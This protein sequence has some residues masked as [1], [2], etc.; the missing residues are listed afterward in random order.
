MGGQFRGITGLRA[1]LV[2]TVVMASLVRLTGLDRHAALALFA[3]AAGQ[4]IALFMVVSGFGLT[5]R[6]LIRA[7][8]WPVFVSRRALRVFP[9]Y[10]VCLAVATWTA[11]AYY[12]TIEAQPWAAMAPPVAAI[13]GDA[14][15]LHADRWPHWLTQ[16]TLVNG[17][18]PDGVLFHAGT[19]P[20]EAAWSLSAIWQFSLLAPLLVAAARVRRHAA[21]LSAAALALFAL[22]RGGWMG[23]YG[24]PD[25][26]P[27]SLAAAS[28]LFA[29]GIATRLALP[30]IA[31][32]RHFALPLVLWSS[33][34][35]ALLAP[36]ALFVA[37]WLAL[38]AWL[39]P[40]TPPA[41]RAGNALHLLLDSRAARWLGSRSYATALMHYPLFQALIA[42][43]AAAGLG[44]W[45]MVAV[46]AMTALPLTLAAA[47]LLHALV[48]RPALA[49]TRYLRAPLLIAHMAPIPAE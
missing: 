23:S 28:P 24:F 20:F 44:Y 12:A 25:A 5:H 3:P 47:V 42:G 16:A 37:L 39:L 29:L 48:E 31:P 8:P 18:I 43:C 46:L 15:T 35:A 33:G 6:V 19:V 34:L 22:W 13:A 11:P 1:W 40:A 32:Q 14:V 4:A 30:L 10:W 41:G 38:V 2:W 21:V 36:H 26:L 7:E 27:G 17:L 45:P 49:L 9:A